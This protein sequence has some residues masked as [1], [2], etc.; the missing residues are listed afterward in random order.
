MQYRWKLR[1]I[2]DHKAIYNKE[3][4]AFRGWPVGRRTRRLHDD[5][6]LLR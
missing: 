2:L 6:R 3:V 5:W 4:V 1:G